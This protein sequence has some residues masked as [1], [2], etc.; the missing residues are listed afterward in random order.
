MKLKRRYIK[1]KKLSK[2]FFT[3]DEVLIVGYPLK[4]DPS[5]RMI[6]QAF[7]KNG[8]KVFALNSHAQSNADIKVYKSLA[9]LPRVPKCAYIYLDK[10]DI[11]PWIGQL[12]TAGVNRVLFHSKKDVDQSQLDECRKAGLETVVACPMMILGTGIHKF[13]GK[14]AG[15][16]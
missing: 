16:R 5:I 1:M 10:N 7:L 2:E 8:L 14:L 9:E 6:L 3:G 4:A 12:A 15:V 11:R 13:H